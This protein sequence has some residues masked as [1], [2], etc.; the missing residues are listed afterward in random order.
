MDI[1]ASSV[2][3]PR[4]VL[5]VIDQLEDAIPYLSSD[6]VSGLLNMLTRVHAGAFPNVHVLL[7]YRGD[8]D[9]KVGRAGRRFSDP[10]S[11]FLVTI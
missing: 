5:I 1:Q 7:C 9:P 4:P 10:Q 8:A 11:D 2:Y 3:A 6:R